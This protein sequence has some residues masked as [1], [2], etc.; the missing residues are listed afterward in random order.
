MSDRI[1]REAYR[2]RRDFAREEASHFKGSVAH[3]LSALS[4]PNG[5]APT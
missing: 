3:H 2:A 4:L 1:K 5:G